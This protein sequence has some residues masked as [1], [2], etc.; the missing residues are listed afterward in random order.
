MRKSFQEALQQYLLKTVAKMSN[1]MLGLAVSEAKLRYQAEASK[2]WVYEDPEAVY[3]VTVN[4]LLDFLAGKPVLEQH[5]LAFVMD[6]AEPPYRQTWQA[7]AARSTAAAVVES[8]ILSEWKPVFSTTGQ[9][10]GHTRE[11]E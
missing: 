6:E 5:S 11:R 4:T 10:L 2:G 7:N 9:L 8:E 3:D 1:E